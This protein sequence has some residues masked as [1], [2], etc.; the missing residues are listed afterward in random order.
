MEVV[1]LIVEARWIIPGEPLGQVLEKHALAARGG[2]IVAIGPV[3][4]LRQRFQAERTVSR[5][6]HALIP[7]LINA[8]THAPMTLLRGLADDLPLDTWLSDYIWPAE[9][10]WVSADFVRD[11]ARLA[12]MEMIRGGTTC[13]QDMYFF[14]DQVAQTAIDVGLRSVVGMIAIEVPTVWANDAEDY[15]TK[16]LAVHDQFRGQP[17]IRTAFAPHAPYSVSDSTL[18]RIRVLADELDVPVHMHVHETAQEVDGALR[19]QGRR[20]LDRLDALGLVTAQLSAVHMT[21]LTDAEIALVAERGVTVVHCPESNLK[22]ASG[23]CRV[24]DLLDA[25]VNVALGTDGAGSNNDLDMFSEMHTATLLG[26]GFGGSADRPSAAEG[27]A[28][29]TRNGA[30][31][32]GWADEIGT[33]E[34]G[35]WADMVAVD[36][37]APATQ[38][39]FNPLSQLVY[40][41]SRD[42]VSDV[43]VAG[44]SLLCQ[45]EFADNK[46]ADVYERAEGWRQRIAAPAVN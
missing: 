18:E 13:F 17:L 14:P 3:D 31:A 1:D 8:H 12:A 45:G 22:L 10:R 43:W 7:G 35:K 36:L 24:A 6:E 41:T 16:G 34:T 29:A 37:R 28:M 11:G 9:T 44:E 21:A 19:D 30:R 32:L 26:K 2:R 42:Q 25:G 39:V 15:L 38:P 23:F 4:S 46:L 27:F 33:L 40:A 5:M 20:P